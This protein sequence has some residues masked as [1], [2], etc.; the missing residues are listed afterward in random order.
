MEEKREE[1]GI[2]KPSPLA[3]PTVTATA[4]TLIYG[5]GKRFFVCA[6]RVHVSAIWP[7]V[8][9][10][11]SSRNPNPCFTGAIIVIVIVVVDDLDTVFV[12][13]SF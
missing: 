12:Y 13:F 8:V 5:I 9:F 10:A 2:G 11:S 3:L 6:I 7:T 4:I 1:K